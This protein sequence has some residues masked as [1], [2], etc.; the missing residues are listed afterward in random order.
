MQCSGVRPSV[1]LSV[2]WRRKTPRMEKPAVCLSV[3]VNF[4]WQQQRCCEATP[5]WAWL[6]HTAS[7][8]VA[9]WLKT[10]TDLFQRSP[11]WPTG[12]SY[13]YK[14]ESVCLSVC[15]SVLCSFLS[16]ATV[17]SGSGQTLARGI[18][19]PYRRSR[20]LESA[21][22]ARDLALRAPGNSELAVGRRHGSSA[23]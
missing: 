1:C 15:L 6:T 11:Q 23:V 3:V 2:P 8:N 16:T 17:L 18:L 22:R 13:K 5:A 10:D 12:T 7:G 21:A 20:G 14:I 4:S 9:V 19:I